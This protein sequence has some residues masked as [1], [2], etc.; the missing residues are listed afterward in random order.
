M[1]LRLPRIVPSK[2]LLTL[3]DIPG[4]R[5]AYYRLFRFLPHEIMLEVQRN[6]MYLVPTAS[7]VELSLFLYGDYE[8]DQTRVFHEVVKRGMTVVDLGAHIGYYTLIAAE[9][10]GP[11]GKVFAF[12]PDPEN[13]SLLQRNVDVS[14]YKNVALVQKA[15]SGKTGIAKLY[16]DS[17][18]WGHSLS[19]TEISKESISVSVTSLDE[20]FSEEVRIDIIKIDIEG[21]EGGAVEG[22]ERI[23]SKGDVKSIFL[24]SHLRELESE[25]SSLKEIVDKL[26]GFGFRFYEISNSG[27][28]EADF[29][30]VHYLASKREASPV[31]LCLR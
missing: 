4:V 10:V 18:S 7:G 26:T 20:F 11:E 22:M 23:L 15:V 1:F 19:S 31:L 12:E 28:R 9:L 25:G 2:L 30:E 21:A 6:K 5:K 3:A 8:K 16:L 14:G 24:S 17:E 29:L 27:M 13:F